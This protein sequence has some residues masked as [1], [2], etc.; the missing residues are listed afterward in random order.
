MR[1]IYELQ[2]ENPTAFFNDAPF[3]IVIKSKKQVTLHAQ[4]KMQELTSKMYNFSEAIY[5]MK[6]LA[7][8]YKNIYPNLNIHFNIYLLDKKNN[9]IK[10]MNKE[11]RAED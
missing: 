7:I 3:I 4:S 1:K 9:K 5:F 8:G 2:F 10:I 6:V 11:I